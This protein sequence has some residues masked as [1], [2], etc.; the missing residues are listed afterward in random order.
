MPLFEKL[1]G[2]GADTVYLSPAP[3][4]HSAPLRFNMAVHRLGGTTV[5]MERFDAAWALELIERHR[6]THTQMVPTMFVRL[7]RLPAERARALRPVVAAR[8]DPRRRAVP[9]RGQGGR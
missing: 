4:Y 8:R 5:V 7:L 3:L 6:V 2:F 9:A 1:Y